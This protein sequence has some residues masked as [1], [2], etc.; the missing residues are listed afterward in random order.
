MKRM[1]IVRHGH[2]AWNGEGRIQ[3][4]SDIA[5]D[6]VGREQA[7]EAAKALREVHPDV[8]YSSDLSR[9]ADTAHTIADAC[10]VEVR[11]EKR[12]R[13]RAYGPW[14]GLTRA[15]LQDRYPEEYAA[16]LAR[17]PFQ[18]SGIEV[19]E[20]VA[21]R[22]AAVLADIA[23]RLGAEDTA[24]IVGH[25]GATRQA[26]A[27]FLGWSTSQAETVRGLGNCRWADLR[28]GPPGWRLFGYNLGSTPHDQ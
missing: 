25:G 13:E 2:T 14:E 22:G 21:A 17:K 8:V 16:W 28:Q 10:G 7:V 4:T 15:E 1:L 18:L 9:A 19:P 12:L 26:I 6:P 27:G 24:I 5:L 20:D 11:V 3:G 23:E